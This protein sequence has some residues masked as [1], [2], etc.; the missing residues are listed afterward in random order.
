MVK[1]TVSE[2]LHSGAVRRILS[3]ASEL[4]LENLDK[5]DLSVRGPC[6]R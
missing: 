5:C 3:V 6:F 2:R 1:K 4:I